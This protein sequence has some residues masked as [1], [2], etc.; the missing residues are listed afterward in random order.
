MKSYCL[1]AALVCFAGCSEAKSPDE[2]MQRE[3]ALMNELADAMKA[4]DSS[5]VESLRS[6]ANDLGARKKVLE[7]TDEGKQLAA[8]YKAELDKATTRMLVAAHEYNKT[9]K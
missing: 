1:P 9:H 3:V 5:K 6:E 7:A 4:N 8:K 2:V